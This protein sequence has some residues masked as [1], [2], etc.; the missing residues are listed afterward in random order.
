[1]SPPVENPTFAAFENYGEVPETVPLDITKDGIT[2]VSSKLSGA[3]GALG[4]EAIELRNWILCFG[5]EL[6]ELRFVVTRMDDWIT[7]SSP[8]WAAY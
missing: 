1:M 5:C 8:P 7:N 6:E 2:W 3:A 4:T